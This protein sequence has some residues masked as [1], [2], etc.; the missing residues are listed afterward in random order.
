MIVYIEGVD[1]SGKSTLANK[2]A[3]MCK[4]LGYKYDRYAESKISTNPTKSDRVNEDYLFEELRRMA[5]DNSTIYILDRGPIS[6][7]IY[8]IFDNYKPVATLEE[9]AKALNSYGNKIIIIY[10]KTGIAERAMITRGDDNPVALKHHKELSKVYDITMK[11]LNLILCNKIVNFNYTKRKSKKTILDMF[12][13]TTNTTKDIL[14]LVLEIAIQ[15]NI[16]RSIK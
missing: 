3:N 1:G 5:N 15:N 16:K 14:N 2:I 8:R 6:D 12:G 4:K 9:L 7:N 13:D 11:L 10:A